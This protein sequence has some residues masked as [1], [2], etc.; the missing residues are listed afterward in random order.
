MPMRFLAILAVCAAPLPAHD[1]GTRVRRFLEQEQRA[2]ALFEQGSTAKAAAAFEAQIAIYPDNPRPYY[3]IACLYARDNDPARAATW[4]K[5]SILHGWRDKEHLAQDTDFDGMR[6]TPEYR[7]CERALNAAL[8]A[9]PRPLPR[10]VRLA[11]NPS[12]GRIGG[13]GQIAGIDEHSA[14]ELAVAASVLQERVL[15]RRERLLGVHAFRKQLFALWDR[16]M[17][18]LGRRLARNGDAPDAG[19]IAHTRVETATS[20]LQEADPSTTYGRRLEQIAARYVL[21]TAEQFQRGYAGSP[22]LSHVLLL[23]AY[24]R[25]RLPGGAPTAARDLR[26]W[27]ADHPHDKNIVGARMQLAAALADLDKRSELRALM[28]ELHKTAA[29]R[30]QVA[31]A[32]RGTLQKAQLLAYGLPKPLLDQAKTA[33]ADGARTVRCVFVGGQNPLTARTLKHLRESKSNALIF[34]IDPDLAAAQDWLN[35]RAG[36]VK[37]VYAPRAPQLLWMRRAPLILTITQD[38]TITKIE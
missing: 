20:Y 2:F 38:G 23:E 18:I 35:D 8:R 32:M 12:R 9:D 36:N 11:T 19:A 22:H 24:A 34:V 33:F 37:W 14:V 13:M 3:N 10:R 30:D 28:D 26:T 7:R 25:R 31:E 17:A 29:Q 16:R 1:T 27:L 6:H 4:L 5:L 21:A 15:R